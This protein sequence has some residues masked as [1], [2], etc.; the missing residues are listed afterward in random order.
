[1][2][3]ILRY[4]GATEFL[5]ARFS[6]HANSRSPTDSPKARWRP[7][8]TLVHSNPSAHFTMKKQTL[9]TVI[10]A[11]CLTV[12]AALFVGGCTSAG[13]WW[14]LF[15]LVPALL[16]VVCAYGIQAARDPSRSGGWLSLDS[17]AFVLM[18]AAVSTFGLPIVLW[19]AHGLGSVTIVFYVLGPLVVI[20]GYITWFILDSD[21][22]CCEE[23]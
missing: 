20:A 15:A 12:G 10:L 22:T 1:M 3:T 13:V 5:T 23:N 18:I 9:G 6:R 11:V 7:A 14:A 16:G 8:D 19:H 2:T 4:F 17:W 21:E